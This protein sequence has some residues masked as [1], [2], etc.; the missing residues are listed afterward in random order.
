[1][2]T[3]EDYDEER[4]RIIRQLSVLTWSLVA[5]ALFFAILGG[6]LLAWIFTGAGLPFLR[7]WLIVS[8][9]L[10]LVPL[11]VHVAPWPRRKDESEDEA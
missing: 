7:T 11:A 9:L 1:M 10:L 6:A 2:K 4:R 8:L 3:P 5:G